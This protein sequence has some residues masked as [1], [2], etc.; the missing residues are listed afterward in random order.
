MIEH[1][2]S[3]FDVVIP[4]RGTRSYKWDSPRG[5]YK[6]LLPM[7]VADMDFQAAPA[8]LEALTSRISHGI[9]GYSRIAEP[10]YEAYQQ[11]VLTRQ[12]VALPAEWMLY[13]Q[14]VLAALATAVQTLSAQGDRVIIQPPVYYPFESLIRHNGREV[15]ENPLIERNGRWLID[16]DHLET[17]A[18]EG[19]R[20][21]LLCSPHNP[22]GRVWTRT[23]LDGVLEIC[24]RHSITVISDEI[25]SDIIMP[26]HEH[27]PL[28][29]LSEGSGVDVVVL[30]SPTKTFNLAGVPM[31]WMI[32]PRAETRAALNRALVAAHAGSANLLSVLAA[33][34]AYRDCAD[35]LDEL[36]RY[37]MTNRTALEEGLSGVVPGL[38]IAPLQGT[39]LAWLDFRQVAVDARGLNRRLLE[40]AEL[41][42]ND[43]AMFG[44]GGDGF[45]RLNLA[46]PRSLVLDAVDRIRRVF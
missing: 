3:R 36:I 43:G 39:Y 16:L 42:L 13:T 15:L 31:A 18:S 32:A 28:F 26:G 12:H 9:F 17:V 11:W 29:A 45:Q 10:V 33:E 37:L 41:R 2:A 1:S 20:V 8:I 30:T 7:W 4:R 19:A 38:R 5:E 34:T 24:L 44:T 35:W 40:E 6:D 25:H 23:E 21:L 46:A 14:G 27:C 22:V